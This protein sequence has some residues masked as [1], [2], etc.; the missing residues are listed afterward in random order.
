MAFAFCGATALAVAIATLST[1][2]LARP[3][4]V[5][6]SMYKVSSAQIDVVFTGHWQEPDGAISDA[7]I[8]GQ[9]SLHSRQLPWG[10]RNFAIFAS[11]S[12]GCPA[13]VW[14]SFFKLSPVPFTL[15]GSWSIPSQIE[16]AAP[17][18]GT[19]SD[20]QRQGFLVVK[21]PADERGPRSGG[22][23]PTHL[24]TDPSG[25]VNSRTRRATP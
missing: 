1:P 23:E 15:S 19:C 25:G 9:A 2:A 13:R 3:R 11:T 8:T 5:S 22:I 18:K 16:G 17:E 12:R 24:S 4:C 10:G 7:N 14:D 21:S 6:A 20:I